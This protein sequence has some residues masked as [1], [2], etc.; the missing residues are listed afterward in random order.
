MHKLPDSSTGIFNRPV[1]LVE[2][3]LITI[4]RQDK[5][6]KWYSIQFVQSRAA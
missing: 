4:W 5:K 3:E 2:R 6:G 1:R